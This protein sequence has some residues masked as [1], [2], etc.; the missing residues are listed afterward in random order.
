MPMKLILFGASGMVGGGALREALVDPDVTAVLAV[1]RR[2]LGLSHPKL[3]EALVPDLFDLSA[4]EA[5]LT[6]YDACLWAVGVT[7]VGKD[8]E[9]YDRLTRRLTLQAA[10][11]LLRLNPGLSFCYCSAAGAG[12]GAMWAQVRAQLEQELLA[13]PFTHA[14]C[15]RPALIQPGPGIKSRTRAYQIGIELLGWSFP[16]FVRH[17]PSYATTT[18]RLGRAMLKVVKGEAGRGILESR[19]IN[20]VGAQT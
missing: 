16:F 11:T 13:M 3:G 17:L 8:R 5:Q 2:P 15:V 19:D 6:G 20:R 9:T 18:E 1:G 7:S 12:G 14:G 4:I 10:Q